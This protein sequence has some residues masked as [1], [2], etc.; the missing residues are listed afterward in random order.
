VGT[1]VRVGACAQHL[2]T[3]K[4]ESCCCLLPAT[5]T[6]T[7]TSNFHSMQRLVQ[8]HGTDLETGKV[9]HRRK[10]KLIEESFKGSLVQQIDLTEFNL[11]APPPPNVHQ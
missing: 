8:T 1:R 3:Y 6:A 11:R 7:T 2:A 10:R 4:R 5:A 9:D